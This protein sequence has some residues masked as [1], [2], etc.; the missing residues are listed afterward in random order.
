MTICGNIWAPLVDHCRKRTPG[1]TGKAAKCES[2]PFLLHEV[3]GRDRQY[4]HALCVVSTIVL[5]LIKDCRSTNAA[6]MWRKISQSL[7]HLI[8]AAALVACGYTS[9]GDAGSSDNVSDSGSGDGGGSSDGAHMYATACLC[10]AVGAGG[11]ALAGFNVNH[12]DVAPKYAGVLMGITNTVATIPGF[13]APQFTKWMTNGVNVNQ[14]CVTPKCYEERE[15]L[16][17]DWQTVF[18]TGAG[19]YVAG[20]LVYVVLASGEKQPWADGNRRKGMM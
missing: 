10:V 9:T 18:F 7:G 19:I 8:A 6:G 5:L 15:T 20:V 13:A 11:F 16:Q 17:H 3:A 2:C 1:S 12:L 14:T 4:P